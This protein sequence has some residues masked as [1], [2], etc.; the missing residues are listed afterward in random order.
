MDRSVQQSMKKKKKRERE[1]ERENE[2]PGAHPAPSSISFQTVAESVARLRFFGRCFSFC[3]SSTH[4][5]VSCCHP[6]CVCVCVCVTMMA[7]DPNR[8]THTSGGPPSAGAK[9]IARNLARFL[10]PASLD[11]RLEIGASHHR[12]IGDNRAVN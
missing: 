3:F 5:G 9:A 12:H 7:S 10:R 8:A 1:R 4:G 6:V 11:R 2:T